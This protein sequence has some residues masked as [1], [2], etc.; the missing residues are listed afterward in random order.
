M[1]LAE[2]LGLLAIA[3]RRFSLATDDGRLSTFSFLTLLFFALFSVLSI[4]ERRAFWMSRPSGAL[5]LSLLGAAVVGIVVG[6]VGLGELRP[7]PLWQMA[8]VVAYTLGFTF[9]VNDL[10][11]T[12]LI[13]RFYHTGAAS[14]KFASSHREH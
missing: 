7:L 6:V 8:S 11:K 4:R 14:G 2:S 5:S 1:M 13:A 9:V 10:V 12:A 3:W